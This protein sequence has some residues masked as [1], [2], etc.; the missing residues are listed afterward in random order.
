MSRNEKE[1]QHHS[2]ND[3]FYST[4]GMDEMYWKG[5]NK[6][7]LKITYNTFAIFIR[8]HCGDFGLVSLRII[9]QGLFSDSEHV[10]GILSFPLSF[11]YDYCFWA[12]LDFFGR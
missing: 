7:Q 2:G 1:S 8:E 9:S 10:L 4:P 5:H 12:Y 6:N 11:H 3:L